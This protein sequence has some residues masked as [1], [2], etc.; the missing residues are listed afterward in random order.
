MQTSCIHIRV[1]AGI[2]TRTG[3]CLMYPTHNAYS[4]L[5]QRLAE[6]CVDQ[7]DGRFVV[8][9]HVQRFAAQRAESWRTVHKTIRASSM[10]EQTER[11]PIIMSAASCGYDGTAV[12]KLH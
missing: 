9:L 5:Q 1:H 7:L 12:C 10:Q 3:V 11:H 2:L 4:Q 8:E 6:A